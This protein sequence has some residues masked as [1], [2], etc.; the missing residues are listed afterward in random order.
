MYHDLQKQLVL[1]LLLLM[2]I[3]KELDWFFQMVH[4]IGLMKENMWIPCLDHDVEKNLVLHLLILMVLM[5]EL[6]LVLQM[7]SMIVLKK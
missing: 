7:A 3:M 4:L 6:G 1:H 2:V 5:K